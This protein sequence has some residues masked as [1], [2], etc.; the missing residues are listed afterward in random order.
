[1]IEELLRAVLAV[2]A[3]YHL[4][5]GGLAATAP[6]VAA[7]VAGSLYA[8]QATETP[9]LRYGV[10]ML[11]L[12]ALALGVLLALAARDPRAHLPV[13]VVV[14]GLQLARAV[15][16]LALRDEVHAA[17]GVPTRRNA[18]NAGVLLAEV[19]VLATG[20]GALSG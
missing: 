20:V 10:R 13:I 11:G 6:R 3:G 5:M 2:L 9:Q 8:L 7:R 15:A 19:V 14:G 1:M 4:L 16:R 12:Y 17:F 18:L